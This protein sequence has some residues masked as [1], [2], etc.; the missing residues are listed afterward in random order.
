[1]HIKSIVFDCPIIYRGIV[2]SVKNEIHAME[3]N[4]YT[5]QYLSEPCKLYIIAVSYNEDQYVINATTHI[6]NK[7]KITAIV[8]SLS[9]ALNAN[10]SIFRVINDSNGLN[11]ES[12][13]TSNNTTNI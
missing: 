10:V 8:N 7:A 11:I 2:Q 1:M 12:V 4:E 3:L 13:S 6:A 5:K 9:K